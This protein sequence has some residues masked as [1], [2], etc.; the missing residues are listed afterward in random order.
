MEECSQPAGRG[1]EDIW[2]ADTADGVVAVSHAVL[3]EL[4]IAY[5]HLK[6]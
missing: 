4:A 3:T 5:D 1:H 2:R 6:I